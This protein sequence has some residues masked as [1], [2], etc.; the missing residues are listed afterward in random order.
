MFNEMCGCGGMG[1]KKLIQLVHQ[2][3]ENVKQTESW[4]GNIL[5]T[6][7]RSGKIALSIHSSMNCS[8]IDIFCGDEIST[9]ISRPK[10][11][12]VRN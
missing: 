9:L 3:V 4:L 6:S 11:I 7:S 8:T 5:E 10:I 12:P 1:F 2:N